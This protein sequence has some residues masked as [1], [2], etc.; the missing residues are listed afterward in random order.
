MVRVANVGET[1][2]VRTARVNR[3]TVLD[4]SSGSVLKMHLKLSLFVSL[5]L[6]VTM[7]RVPDA[8]AQQ[9]APPP[10]LGATVVTTPLTSEGIFSAIQCPTGLSAATFG[11]DGYRLSVGGRCRPEQDWAG[12]TPSTSAVTFPDGEL[13]VKVKVTAGIQ[14]ALLALDVRLQTGGWYRL[15]WLPATGSANLATYPDGREKILAE[16]TDL[17]REQELGTVHTMAL[18]AQGSQLWGLIDDRPILMTSDAAF[19]VGGIGFDLLRTGSVDDAEQVSAV[20]QELRVSSLAG[21]PPDRIATVRGAASGASPTPTPSPAASTSQPSQAAVARPTAS[22]SCGPAPGQYG[23]TGL[24]ASM[25]GLGARTVPAV[26]YKVD[27]ALPS[28]TTLVLLFRYNDEVGGIE[29]IMDSWGA[30]EARASHE[31]ALRADIRP[32]HQGFGNS[33]AIGSGK[34]DGPSNSQWTSRLQSN[35]TGRGGLMPGGYFFYVYMGEWKLQGDTYRFAPDVTG[36]IGKF[37]CNVAD[38]EAKK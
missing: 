38:D 2:S 18:R 22:G 1:G 28:P 19:S 31:G 30:G 35:Y 13:Q 8:L 34:Y 6:L 32:E 10:E 27:Y 20:V 24:S 21:S 37:G 5:M 29:F 3:L 23:Y 12:L 33:L 9:G 11:A 7:I 4:T 17:P 14:R 16:R 36:P 25:F 26:Y 15:T